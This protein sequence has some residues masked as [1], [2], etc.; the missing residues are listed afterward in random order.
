[1]CMGR[2]G[3]RQGAGVRTVNTVITW[4][5]PLVVVVVVVYLESNQPDWGHLQ[6][7]SD[8]SVTPDLSTGDCFY[9]NM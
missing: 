6:N 4:T 7:T 3:G 8:E 9:Y 5:G 1:M 2:V